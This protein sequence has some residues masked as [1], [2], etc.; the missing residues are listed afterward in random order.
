MRPVLYLATT[1]HGFGHAVRTAAVAAKVQELL[2]STRL[3]LVTMV[4]E[5]LLDSYIKGEYELRR[6]KLDIGVV[7]KDSFTMD[8]QQTLAQIRNIR[9]NAENIIAEEVTFLK[10]NQAQLILADIPPLAAPI[11]HAADIPCWFMGNFGWDFIYRDWGAEFMAESDWITAQYNQGDRLFRLP[12]HEPMTPF[13]N[14]I[15]VGLIGDEPN[16]SE[17]ELRDTF[18]LTK[19]K[20]KTILLTF[21]GLGLDGIPYDTLTQF[22]DYQFITFDRQAPDLPNLCPVNDVAYRPV[23]FFPLCDRLVSKPGFGTFS[24]AMRQDLP[25][26]TLPREDFA[27]APV[28]LENLQR[29]SPHQILDPKAFREGNWD[30]LRQTPNLPTS[31]LGLDKK[32]T[33][34][35]AQAIVTFLTNDPQR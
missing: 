13:P 28:L 30:F 10:D 11:A 24:E 19:P 32:G 31:G 8:K 2:P 17:A 21:G 3:I 6:R 4:P 12:F 25:I 26:A 1:S 33:E 35:I 15:D 16:F 14:P 22:P 29:Y 5:W 27:E 34:A 9:Q 7:Q 23:D 20:D 18:A